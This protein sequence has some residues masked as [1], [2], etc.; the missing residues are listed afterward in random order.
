MKKIS[1]AVCFLLM[2]GCQKTSNNK[3]EIRISTPYTIVELDDNDHIHGTYTI[4][5]SS[6]EIEGHEYIIS[7]TT[8]GYFIVGAHKQ[9]CKFCK[10]KCK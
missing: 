10:E 6:I 4:I 1:I 2:F 7:R 8:H 9:N 3:K 5:Y